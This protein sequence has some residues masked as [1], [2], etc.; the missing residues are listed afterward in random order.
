MEVAPMAGWLSRSA[1][2]LLGVGGAVYGLLELAIAPKVP[3]HE[4][5]S[6]QVRSAVQAVGEPVQ[7]V[8][9]LP[10]LVGV[11]GPMLRRSPQPW[12]EAAA[13]APAQ[14]GVALAVAPLRSGSFLPPPPATSAPAVVDGP[15]QDP[16]TRVL[17]GPL[18]SNPLFGIGLI[19]LA[20]AQPARR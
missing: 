7:P 6:A 12:W 17:V 1:G 9:P 15:T 8:A 14:V 11:A 13:Y 5:P 3:S 2:I 16:S 10:V 4:P 20:A 19:A 18:A